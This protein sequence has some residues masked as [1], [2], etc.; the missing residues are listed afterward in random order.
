M[1][2]Q[3]LKQKLTEQSIDFK[4]NEDLSVHSTMRVTAY[5]SLFIEISDIETLKKILNILQSNPVKFLIIGDG[6]N[7]LFSKDFEGLVLK[8]NIKGKEIIEEND[9]YVLFKVGAGE[10]WHEFVEYCVNRNLA[11]NENLAYIPGTVGAAPIQNIAAYGQVQEDT[12]ESL[13]AINIKTGEIK[14]F[15]KEEC[16]FA[17]RKSVF[18]TKYKGEYIVLSVNYKLYKVEEYIPETS[19]HSR[20][21]S[22]QGELEQ[23]AK[24]TY[25]LKDVFNAVVSIRKK[26]LPQIEE[27]GTLGSFFLNPFV[28]KEKLEQLQKKFPDIQFYPVEKMQYPGRDDEILKASSIVKIPAG[29]LLEEL[30]WRGKFEGNVGS[31]PKHALCVVTKGPAKGED[32]INFIEKMKKSVEDATGIKLETEIN[33]V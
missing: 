12:F 9:E 17:Y 20:Y 14:V 3:T 27:E 1:N 15:N 24:K 5:A 7:T 22:L 28:T 16:E 31:S 11:G 21:E 25:T 19:Y 18:K 33:I 4:E 10:S 23:I 29:W 30:G 13:E 8:M 32:V 26:K 2:Q 6:S